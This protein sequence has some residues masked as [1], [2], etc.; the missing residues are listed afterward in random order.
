MRSAVQGLLLASLLPAAASA[1]TAVPLTVSGNEARGVIDLPGGIRAELTLTFEDVVGLNPA[2]LD[3]S[4]SLVSPTDL[5]LLGRLASLDVG[6]PAAFP[7]LLRIEP[8]ASSALTFAG[9]YT[10]SLY[11]HNLTFDPAVPLALHK[12]PAGGAFRDITATEGRGSYR[13]GGGSGDF[14]DFMIV[15]DGRAIDA[16]IV[17]KFDSL[18]ATLTEHAASM[19]AE[20]A[21]RLQTHLSQARALYD[22]GSTLGAMGEIIAFSAYAKARSGFDIPDVWRA[23]DSSRV[24]VAGLLRSG[25]DTLRFSLDR[26]AS[27]P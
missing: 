5:T 9:I 18:Q 26:K 25:A 12:A 13:V 1:Q 24:N 15:V 8:S 20:T 27:S 7:V 2:A 19:T 23:H 6:I 10:I 4:A 16:V 17:A 21:T 3:V 11:T 22:S 14:S